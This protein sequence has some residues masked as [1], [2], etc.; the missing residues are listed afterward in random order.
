MKK[1][2][3]YI[4]LLV[5]ILLMGCYKDANIAPSEDIGTSQGGS[6]AKFTVSGN[7]LYI[8]DDFSLSAYDISSESEIVFKSNIGLPANQ[9][10]TIFPYGSYLYIGTTT[11]V[12]IVD[13]STPSSP[14]YLSEYQH[15]VSCDPVVT[16]GTYA[17]VT[18]RSGNTCGQNSDE[19]QIIDFSDINNPLLVS[20]YSL[21]SP[22]GLA[23]NGNTLF[24]CDDGI[25]IL[26]VSDKNNVSQL[27]H[28][29]GIP[30]NDV[31]FYN[32]QLLVTAD[33]GFYQYNVADVNNV[34]Q[35]GQFS[36]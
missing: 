28:V 14:R 17:Y 31:I 8:I 32:N 30:A 19:L 18:L 29:S 36:F 15:I 26:D 22:K 7:Y 9:L 3:H 1:Y 6:T 16:D 10:E 20:T 11:G 21:T 35:I 24:V 25:R 2:I 5:L 27:N 4:V 34:T 33:D 13:I 23:V 12:L